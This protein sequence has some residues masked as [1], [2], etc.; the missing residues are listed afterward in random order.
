MSHRQRLTK[1]QRNVTNSLGWKTDKK[2]VVFE[3]DDWGSI[4]MPSKNVYNKLVNSE[5]I[6]RNDVYANYDSL[7]C[8]SDVELLINLLSQFKDSKDK[9]PVFTLNF[10]MT[11]PDFEGIQESSFKE[12]K[13]I[14]FYDYYSL[15]PEHADVFNLIKDG[16]ERKVFA[17]EYHGREH[18]NVQRWLKHLT[19]G[20]KPALIAFNENCFHFKT[21]RSFSKGKSIFATLDFDDKNDTFLLDESLS[22][23][24]NL[25]VSC[26][27][28]SPKSFIAPNY[29]WANI[30]E[31]H[32]KGLGIETIQGTKYQ[33][34][35]I[36]N[37]SNYKRSYRFTGSTNSSG[38]INTV[39]NCF[40]E[41][42][43]TR[44]GMSA[45]NTV[46]SQI[47]NAFY[48]KTPAIISTHRLNYIGALHPENRTENLKLLSV[49]LSEITR[50]WPEVEFLSSTELARL[51]KKT[52]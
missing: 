40:F 2:I 20:Y 41:P 34:V 13:Y 8:N 3:S 22:D 19:S 18:V 48:W 30:T 36:V 29:I 45:I 21:S 7:E 31:S 17:P 26:F 52:K 47:D 23:G 6:N 50:R 37:S 32:I 28:K 5:V 39:R 51:I 11:N 14:P 1:I 25:F 46:L 27:N 12:Y 49:L 35:P 4:R 43:S 42:T 10:I 9:H 44:N 24:I 15:Y 16:I 33:N 38:L